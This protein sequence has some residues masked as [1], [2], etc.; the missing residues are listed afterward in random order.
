[1]VAV[2]SGTSPIM[3]LITTAP[4]D[5]TGNGA[6]NLF[7][8]FHAIRTGLTLDVVA[9]FGAAPSQADDYFRATS[10][11]LAGLKLLTPGG[12]ATIPTI[13]EG[14]TVANFTAGLSILVNNDPA[15]FYAETVVSSL[16]SSHQ[17]VVRN[18][19][20]SG[21]A[22]TTDADKWSSVRTDV[23]LNNPGG[24]INDADFVVHPIQARSEARVTITPDGTNEVGQPHAF[25]V[26]V[27]QDSGSGFV[28]AS[29]ANVTVVLTGANGAVPDLISPSDLPPA[30]TTTIS[31]LTNTSGQFVVTFTSASAGQVIANA[32]ASLVVNGQP[33]TRDTDPTTTTISAGPGGSGPATKT[34]VDA[35]I[36]LSPLSATNL[37]GDP[38]T[39]VAQVLQDDGLTAA[40]G[41]DGVTGLAPAPNGTLVT[42]ALTNSGGA[43]ATFVGSS[44]ATLTGGSGSVQIN[45]PTAGTVTINATTTLV[46]GGVALVRDTDPA[47][48]T[49]SAGPGGSGPATKIYENLR[50]DIEKYLKNLTPCAG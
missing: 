28:P 17:L 47:T 37:V 42:F 31:G 18:G 9:G 4:T 1:M 39:I 43:T 16:G 13:G 8:Y 49:I 30:P 21:M 32:T 14:V 10:S 34:F 12:A 33:L 2:Y 7:D 22:D 38:H 27:Q 40:Q 46:V 20:V 25:T 19:A 41:G 29:G 35:R 24:F 23:L 26:T 44:A 48:T 11:S 36:V 15:I 45:S 50:I 6:V 3:G 5:L